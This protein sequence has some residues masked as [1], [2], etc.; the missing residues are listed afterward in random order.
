MNGCPQEY[1]LKVDRSNYYLVFFFIEITPNGAAGV[2]EY[3]EF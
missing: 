1:I 2:E 3:E